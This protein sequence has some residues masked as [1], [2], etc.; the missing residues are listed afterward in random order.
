M[1]L[2][3]ISNRLPLKIVEQDNE[4]KIIA[5]QGG[6]AT[7]LDSLQMNLDKHWIGW[8]GMYLEESDK[9][10]KI[11]RL[12]QDQ[13]FHPV[14]LSPKQIEDYYEGY[15]NSI[16][17]PLCHYFT[18]YVQYDN[19]CWQTYK[20]VNQLFA[21]AASNIIEG[22][23]IV[24]VQDYQL[25]LVPGYI[26]SEHSDVS[27]GYFHH[28][29]FPSYELFRTLPERKELLNGL[30]G[31]DLIGFHT[32]T[33][34]RHFMDAIYNVLK[35]ECKLDEIQLES[36]ISHV[37]TFPMGINYEKYNDAILN[38][39]IRDKANE[40][41]TQ[42]GHNKLILSVDRLD[43]SKGIVTRL[44]SF[45]KFLKAYPEYKSKVSLVMIVSPSRDNVE[46]YATL[47]EEIDKMVGDINGRYSTIDWTPVY[48]FYHSFEFEEL[49]AL[50]H[51][52]DIALITPLRD[53]MNL[54]AK[55]YLATKRDEP[56]VLILSEM[57]GAAIELS[58][59]LIVNPTDLEEIANALNKA[60]EMPVDEQLAS[61]KAMQDIISGQTVGQWAR[62]FVEELNI[63]RQQNI[64]LEQ[65]IVEK[66]NFKTI[67]ERYDQANER[68]L[69]LD[70]DGTLVGF[71]NNPSKA[72]PTEKLLR[73]LENLS[74]DPRNHV[75]ISS[76]R[77]RK[78]LE[79]WFG[80]MPIDM[81][82]EHGA[83]YKEDGKWHNNM[84]QI[85]WDDEIL[86]IIRHAVKKT[87]NSRIEIKDTALVWHYRDVDPWLAELRVN[88]LL[89][90]L[91]TP[92]SRQNL[93]IMKGNKVLEVKSPE[94]TKGSE[95]K[96][97]LSKK[98]YDFIMAIGD[99][100]TD[101]DMFLALPKEAITIKVG[102]NTKNAQYNLPIQP[103]TLK[104]L[105]KI[106]EKKYA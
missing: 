13:N 35:L 43:Y 27:I 26:R 30:L 17:W 90:A 73:I 60:L 101:E 57:A 38:P 103:L 102:I 65:K 67:R 63:V 10:D 58:D 46:I 44:K 94:F 1:K 52:A 32:Y 4:I 80:N 11:D 36:R 88:Q 53:G 33:Y 12:M 19:E 66:N 70:Y 91:L 2:I 95:A 64:L 45:E 8:P 5:S 40:F 48:Y 105:E 25:M 18:N 93:S 106:N 104:L 59:A 15:S 76:G 79:K 98:N 42:F 31:A 56:G 41:K 54:V 9:K 69:L 16:L 83:F 71:T 84:Q 82:A 47:K 97:I 51:I 89:N 100:T 85:E 74:A 24:W 23:D 55:E 96:R 50:Y 37:D 7:G 61:L 21:R 62:D 99:D 92:V 87:P 86:E 81:A 39:A 20:E 3:I 14:Y 77:D 75:V 29:P 72:V 49:A 34:M 78:I 28:I 22:G 6:V 68:L